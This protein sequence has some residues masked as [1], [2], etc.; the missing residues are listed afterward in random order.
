MPDE[1]GA[2]RRPARRGGRRAR[3]TGLSVAVIVTV[4]PAAAFGSWKFIPAAKSMSVGTATLTAPTLTCD[5]LTVVQVGLHWTSVAGATGYDVYRSL[6]G[7][8]YSLLTGLGGLLDLVTGIPPLLNTYNYKVKARSNLWS[9]PFSNSVSAGT[10]T[11][12]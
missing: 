12:G 3:L 6:N 2:P 11:C 1:E 10:L 4:L 7:G 5:A 8:S 9:S